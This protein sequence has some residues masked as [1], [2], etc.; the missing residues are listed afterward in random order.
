MRIGLYILLFFI[1]FLSSCKESPQPSTVS[2]P[3]SS[4]SEGLT[5]VLEKDDNS[6]RLEWQKP[7]ELIALLDSHVNGLSDKTI[8]DIGSG[9]GY[10]TIRFLYTGAHV[11]ATDIDPVMVRLIETFKLNL[12]RSVQKKLE[13][14]LATPTDPM[15]NEGEADI[16]AII[17]VIS[18]IDDRANYV[19]SIKKG[20]KKGGTLMIV[21][22]KLKRLAIDAPPIEERVP[23]Y[24]MEKELMD[25]GYKNLIT[26]D[27]LLDNQ[28]IILVQN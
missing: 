28:Y 14:R 2:E 3:A 18:V 7:S 27:K 6:D 22:Y 24:T 16:I 11:I 13:T 15:I 19:K 23:V 20:L 17:N 8:V 5:E 10:F 12:P 1:F 4:P 21:D 25:A 26:N 9:T